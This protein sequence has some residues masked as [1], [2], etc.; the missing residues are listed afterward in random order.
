V[1]TV[2]LTGA[3][4]AL[5][6]ELLRR[7]LKK[8]YQVLCLVRASDRE[9]AHR[10]IRAIIGDAPHVRAVRGDITEPR[11]GISDIDRELLVG[12]IDRIVHCAASISFQDK[13]ETHRVNVDGVHHLLELADVLDVWRI[14]HI[15]TAYVAGDA[16]VFSEEGASSIRDRPRNFYEETKQIGE[17]MVRAWALK[18]NDRRYAVYRPSILIGREDGTSPT[19]D[20]YYGYFAPIHRIAEAMR[21]RA[22]EVGALAPGV[23]IDLTSG[24]VELPLVLQASS[25]A[26]LNLVPIDWVAD[27]IVELLRVPPRNETYNLVNLEPPLVRW[28]IETSLRFLKIRGVKIV[29]SNEEKGQALE[30]QSPLVARLQ[31]QM[32]KILGQ[33]HPYTNHEVEFKMRAPQ[34]ALGARFR[35]HRRLDVAFVEQL[36]GFALATNWGVTGKAVQP[37]H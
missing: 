16:E 31:R 29:E 26:T 21:A 9:A 15:S 20:A 4:G 35:Q 19:F 5:G 12:R 30:M 8:E 13:E 7:L 33:Y 10:R 2:L 36:L 37:A 6:S 22:R 1:E 18:R 25:R 23:H 3:T 11:C 28:V 17:T 14:D 32:D 34:K 24:H 27:M